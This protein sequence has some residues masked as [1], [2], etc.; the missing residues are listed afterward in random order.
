[1]PGVR[2]SYSRDDPLGVAR[3]APA[4]SIQRRCSMGARL[5]AEDA[6]L[7]QRRLEQQAVPV[8][9]LGDV[10]DA[11]LAAR[12]GCSGVMSASPQDDRARVGAMPMIASTS[13]AWPLPSTPAMP[14]ISP[15]WTSK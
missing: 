2:T 9:V 4:R 8:T 12:G 7:P 15:L 10:A 14:R 6:V 13:S 5:V 11:G 1:M 3:A